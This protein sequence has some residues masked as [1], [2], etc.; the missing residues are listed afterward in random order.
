M[1]TIGSTLLSD[2]LDAALIISKQ[3]T[4]SDVKRN[5]ILPKQQT[6]SVLM[7]MDGGV[8]AEELQNGKVVKVID[9][10]EGDE[11]MVTLRSRDNKYEFG[12]GWY[13]MKYSLDLQVGEILKLYWYQDQ[14]IFVVLNFDHTVQHVPA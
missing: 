4:K 7:R 1:K 10:E 9:L 11:Y 14:R 2:P 13:T 5:V 6:E 3:L 8:T 12:D